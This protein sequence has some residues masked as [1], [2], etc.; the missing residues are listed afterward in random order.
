MGTNILLLMALGEVL[1]HRI[2]RNQ[3]R[4]FMKWR[5][6]LL[7][8]TIL[9]ISFLLSPVQSFAETWVLESS[10]AGECPNC[11]IEVINV[12]PDIIQ[13]TGNNGW[14]GFAAY[15]ATEGKFIGAS[16]AKEGMGGEYEQVLFTMEVTVEK[17]NLTIHASSPSGN[18]YST[19][20]K[21]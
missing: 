5:K 4:F 2:I 3:K 15:D 16:Q 13:V 9:L 17:E 21:K 1:T 14:V 18:I 10:T 20:T 12:T 8:M 11:E 19:Y 6:F 7:A